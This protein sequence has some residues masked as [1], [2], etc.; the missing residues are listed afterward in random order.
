MVLSYENKVF[1]KNDYDEFEINTHESW[2]GHHQNKWHYSSVNLLLN[3]YQRTGS[4]ERVKGSGCPRNVTAKEDSELLEDLTSSQED[5]P[6][7][8]KHLGGLKVQLV[9]QDLQCLTS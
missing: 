6:Q 1:I 2:K 4:I 8:M 5:E 3:R 7:V 9:L